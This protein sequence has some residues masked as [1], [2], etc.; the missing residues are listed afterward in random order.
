MN[1][2]LIKGDVSLCAMIFVFACFSAFTLCLDINQSHQD[3]I[4]HRVT[5]TRSCMYGLTDQLM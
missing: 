1:W 4:K 3:F 5:K 2:Q